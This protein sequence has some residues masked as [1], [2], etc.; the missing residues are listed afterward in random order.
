MFN[1]TKSVSCSMQVKSPHIVPVLA[2]HRVERA[3]PAAR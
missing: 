1:Y 3:K 2:V